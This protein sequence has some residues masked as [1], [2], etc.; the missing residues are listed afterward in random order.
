MMTG[1]DNSLADVSFTVFRLRSLCYRI[2]PLADADQS[3]TKRVQFL[4]PTREVSKTTKLTQCSFT[5]KWAGLNRCSLNR[6][7][8]V[9]VLVFVTSHGMFLQLRFCDIDRLRPL[10]FVVYIQYLLYLI[11]H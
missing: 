4:I 7:R 5:R 3:A 11:N 6:W 1:V 9:L 10:L 8:C 2:D